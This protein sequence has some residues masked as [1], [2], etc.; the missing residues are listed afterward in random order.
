LISINILKS[1]VL[2]RF[3]PETLPIDSLFYPFLLP[4]PIIEYLYCKNLTMYYKCRK[5]VVNSDGAT[6]APVLIETFKKEITGYLLYFNP[7][8]T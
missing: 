7:G 8:V 2:S 6:R 1:H 5:N 4:L 3:T